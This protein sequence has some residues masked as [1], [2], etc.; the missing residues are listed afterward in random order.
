MK[1]GME[2]NKRGTFLNP[3]EGGNRSTHETLMCSSVVQRLPGMHRSWI[4]K[5]TRNKSTCINPNNQITKGL[6]LY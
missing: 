2:K 3:Q 1:T 6:I 4:L 5:E